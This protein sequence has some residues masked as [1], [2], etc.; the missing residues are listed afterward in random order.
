MEPVPDVT[1]MAKS[2]QELEELDW[3]EPTYNSAVDGRAYSLRRLPLERL[4]IDDIRFLVSHEIGLKWVLPLA[5]ER[6]LV[7]PLCEASYYA[8]DLLKSVIRLDRVHFTP[9][10]DEISKLREALGPI[11]PSELKRL[12]CP[13]DVVETIALFLEDGLTAT[14]ERPPTSR[15]TYER[16][17]THMRWHAKHKLP[18]RPG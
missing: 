12:E 1:S 14:F 16:W 10:G 8:G 5:L 11:Q 13:A 6:L 15:E 4:S 17:V 9:S 18:R 7:E 3:G 2:L